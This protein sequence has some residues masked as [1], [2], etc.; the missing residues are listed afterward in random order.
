MCSD[1]ETLYDAEREVLD[2]KFY[3]A[4]ISFVA[5]ELR[6]T[7]TRRLRAGFL[8]GLMAP[9]IAALEPT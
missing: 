1:P 4:N 7:A 3:I 6:G 5:R 8:S 9:S 2:S